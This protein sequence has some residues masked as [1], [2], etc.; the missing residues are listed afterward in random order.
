MSQQTVMAVYD[1]R[2]DARSAVEALL[3]QG[4][5][6]REVSLLSRAESDDSNL[7]Q[8]QPEHHSGATGAATGSVVGGLAGLLPGLG[9][10]TVPGIGAIVVVGPIASTLVGVVTGAVMGSLMGVLMDFGVPEPDAHLYT[11]ALRRGS[12]IVAVTAPPE[13]VESVA[14]TLALHNAVDLSERAREWKDQGWSE[15]ASL[16]SAEPDGPAPISA[17]TPSI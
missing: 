6:S 3:E 4:F 5:S 8:Y 2:S 10:L 15:P 17:S 16:A 7:D 14:E 13:R 11:E 1:R 12:T 9:L